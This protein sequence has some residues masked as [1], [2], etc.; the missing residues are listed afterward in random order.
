[1]EYLRV[2]GKIQIIFICGESTRVLICTLYGILEDVDHVVRFIVSLNSFLKMLV[3]KRKNPHDEK[4]LQTEIMKFARVEAAVAHNPSVSICSISRSSKI[5]WTSV[6]RILKRRTFHPC[7][8]SLHR[9]LH[10]NDF[11]NQM[12]F[13]DKQMFYKKCFVQKLCVFLHKVVF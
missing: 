1:M 9:K 13:Y 2:S 3:C 5:S 7:K 4:Q 11:Q 10:G 6:Q 8:V 12:T